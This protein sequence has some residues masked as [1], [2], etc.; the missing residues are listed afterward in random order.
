MNRYKIRFI[1]NYPEINHEKEDEVL[2]YNYFRQLIK[3]VK[4]PE[5]KIKR[6]Y[7]KM[8]GI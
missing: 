6:Y 3:L 1:F 4:D 8:K 2:E 7:N 5:N